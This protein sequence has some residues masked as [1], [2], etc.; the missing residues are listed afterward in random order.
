MWCYVDAHKDY[1]IIYL[2]EKRLSIM[3]RI[4]IYKN[5]IIATILSFISYFAMLGGIMMLFDGEFLAFVVLFALGMLI[6]GIG[7]AVSEWKRFHSF[8]KQLQKKGLIPMIQTNTQLALQV[9]DAYPAKKTV[10]YIRTLNPA[11]AQIL[12]QRL[13]VKK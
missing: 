5:S 3:A 10:E 11:A 1:G 2:K 13:S 4:P 7:S 9:Y 12:D 6:A 8:K